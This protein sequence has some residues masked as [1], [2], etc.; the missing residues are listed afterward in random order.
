[1][2]KKCYKQFKN[3]KWYTEAEINQL[4]K[5]SQRMKNGEDVSQQAKDLLSKGLDELPGEVVED[6]L[7]PGGFTREEL[8]KDFD[9]MSMLFDYSPGEKISVGEIIEKAAEGGYFSEPNSGFAREFDIA[10]K[11]LTTDSQGF[12]GGLNV[13][14]LVALMRAMALTRDRVYGFQK[15]VDALAAAGQSTAAAES[16]LE[17]AKSQ[18]DM[19]AYAYSMNVTDRARGMAYVLHMNAI[20][21]DPVKE[22][23]RLKAAFPNATEKELKKFKDIVDAIDAKRK[24]LTQIELDVEKQK[25]KAA[26]AAAT[27]GFNEV[28]KEAKSTTTTSTRSSSTKTK[29]PKSFSQEIAAKA[30]KDPLAAFKEMFNGTHNSRIKFQGDGNQQNTPLTPDE[31]KVAQYETILAYAKHL[32]KTGEA[33]D[34]ESVTKKILET[35]ENMSDKV[36]PLT[37]DDIMTAFALKSANPTKQQDYVKAMAEIRAT[38]KGIKELSAMLQGQ[39]KETKPKRPDTRSEQQ[40]KI[41]NLI[42][43]LQRVQYLGVAGAMNPAEQEELFTNLE[44]ISEAYRIFNNTANEEVIRQ[45]TLEIAETLAK[46]KAEKIEKN[47]AQK[48]DDLENKRI[49]DTR[50]TY[51]KPFLTQ[52]AFKHKEDIEELKRRLKNQ[53]IEGEINK[54]FEKYSDKK[55]AGVSLRSLMKKK[56]AFS[57]ALTFWN[58]TSKYKLGGDIGT[59]LLHGG[60]HTTTV[61]GKAITYQ[62][63]TKKGREQISTNLRGLANFWITSIDSFYTGFK[64]KDAKDYI[65]DQYH[66]MVHNPNAVLARQLGL[67]V[68][69][70]FST[71]LITNQDDYFMGKGISDL[72]EGNTM[73]SSAAK[74]AF[75]KF[76]KSSEGAYVMGLNSLRLSMFEAYKDTHPTATVEELKA[77]AREI[78][79]STGKGSITNSKVLSYIFTAPKLYYSR[80]QLILGTPKYLTLLNSSDPVKRATARYRIGNNAAF[81]A[82]HVAVMMMAGL[83]GWEW[84]TDPRS[85]NFLKLVKGDETMDLTAGLGKWISIMFTIPVYLDQKATGGYWMEKVWGP[86]DV[87]EE[88]TQISDHPTAFGLKRLSY[89][90]H[91]SLHA[92]WGIG[93]GGENAIGQPYGTDLKSSAYGWLV[94]SYAP[95]SVSDLIEPGKFVDEENQGSR[96]FFKAAGDHFKQ[97]IGT[98]FMSYDNNI[99]HNLVV[100]YLSNL[101]YTTKGELK[102]GVEPKDLIDTDVV[103]KALPEVGEAG[104]TNWNIKKRFK[105]ELEHSLGSRILDKIN[106]DGECKYSKAELKKIVKTEA[107]KLAKLYKEEYY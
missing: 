107:S 4:Q 6:T 94:N 53:E 55:Y 18:Y 63:A 12:G 26:Q 38:I 90:G 7:L 1:M 8:R 13:L 83:F 96:P 100:D 33:K 95:M 16:M 105:S 72:L 36:D 43:D 60:F 39:L 104:I 25:Q 102:R 51:I 5:L 92:L 17:S 44:K 11:A 89:L 74:W 9:K 57:D 49:V 29:E 77:I 45:K 31:I 19:F 66:Q 79:I 91:G 37:A 84:E 40:K 58:L 67:A 30:K 87:G 68:V 22:M 103:T 2:A 78:N 82:G 76:D 59:L 47:L 52:N 28:N 81:L 20:L 14:E 80:L 69:R 10:T 42:A 54:Y 62:W 46:L 85:S 32:L 61:I 48:L 27:K 70:P 98:G 101:E 106:E 65:L 41:K 15:E 73:V 93:L 21:F 34:L 86:P 75:E 64:E 3:G 56:R 35:Y 23:D 24:E 99:R 71:E 50:K 88:F 97:V